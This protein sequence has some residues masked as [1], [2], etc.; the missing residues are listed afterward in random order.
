MAYSGPFTIEAKTSDFLERDPAIFIDGERLSPAGRDMLPVYDPS[1]GRPIAHMV[2]ALDED[3]DRAVRSASAAFRDGRWRNMR[4]ADR[5]RILYRFS[6]LIEQNAEALAQ[7]ESLEQGKSIHLAR[8]FASGASSEWLR[9]AAGLTTKIT[10]QSLELSLPPGPDHWT[11]YT[12]R[13]PI[14]VVAAIAPWNFPML[15]AIWKIAPALAAGCSI[16]LKP[17]EF[18]PLS[19]LWLAELAIEAGVPAGVFN[20]V[21]GRGGG[22][23]G[24]L[25]R[26]RL[27]NKISFT[28][29][30]ATGKAIGHCAMDA[31]VPASLELGGKNPAIV[32][33]DADMDGTVAGLMM[34]AFF[35]QG[36]V[37]AAASRLYVEAAAHDRLVAALEAA[38]RS[39]PVGP[40]LDP[41]AQVNPLVSA[42]HLEKVNR[43]LDDARAKGATVIGGAP[44]P[45]DGG[46]YA[47]PALVLEAG[48]DVA[49]VREEVFGPLL[50]VA[51]V[52]DR[53]E[54]V[55][56]AND[57]EMGLTASVWTSDLSAA[58]T[59]TRQ[60]EAGT[61]WV[62][63]HNFIDPNMPFGGMKQSGI[64]RDFGTEWL[65]AYTDIKSVCIAH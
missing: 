13:E 36:Q 15:I 9:Y 17:S 51:K 42:V 35:N 11:A 6:G 43:Y 37:C 56:R 57:T 26:H 52:A 53:Q 32:L 62:N 27:V 34:G 12:R 50:N 41:D 23:G 38:I 24:A 20:V 16:V 49:L 22:A 47:G 30:T 29:S 28:G 7:L 5:E 40:G 48:D 2:D 3:V 33:A 14:G 18:T 58:M 10:G 45:A 59:L 63:A 4:P 31:M 54:A 61:V 1:S 25:V 55:A 19:A 65:N 8:L 39:M 21:T 60:L 44:V 64:G 46:Y